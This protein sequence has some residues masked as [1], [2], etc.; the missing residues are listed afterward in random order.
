MANIISNE[1]RCIKNKKKHDNR[2]PQLAATRTQIKKTRN[3]LNETS[4]SSAYKSIDTIARKGIIHKNKANRTKSR[5]ARAL[6]NQTN[7]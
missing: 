4:L 1:K 6:N 7:A 2:H 3:D 5:L